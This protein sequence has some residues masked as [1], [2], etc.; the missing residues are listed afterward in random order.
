[1]L[2]RAL[3]LAL[4]FTHLAASRLA[5]ESSAGAPEDSAEQIADALGCTHTLSAGV[6]FGH[7]RV[8]CLQS[9]L[10]DE[11]PSLQKAGLINQEYDQTYINT[12]DTSLAAVVL[13]QVTAFLLPSTYRSSEI[14]S[15]TVESVLGAADDFGHIVDQSV[16]N[17]RFTRALFAK[18]DWDHFE[19]R[20]L[21][22][23]APGFTASP[24][25]LR[26][27]ANEPDR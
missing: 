5:A 6:P 14:D 3:L 10:V 24:W 13:L 27:T 2:H 1:M 19:T 17:F 12:H 4:L 7:L 23:I 25:L 26:A 9:T 21:S 8:R 18:I 15:L 16:F 20:R 11:I 22:K